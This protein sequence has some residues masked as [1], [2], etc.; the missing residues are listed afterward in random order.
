MRFHPLRRWLTVLVLLLVAIP[1]ARSVFAQSTPSI[2]EIFQARLAAVATALGDNPRYKK[3][4]PQYRERLTE[5]VAGNMLFVLVHELAHAAVSEL[6]LPVLGKEEDA[7][8]AF[9]ATRLIG[10]GSM[11]SSS[12]RHGRGG[13]LVHGRSPRP[14]GRRHG[15]LLR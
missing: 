13:R 7:A 15:P 6:G 12:R 4:S 2:S 9:A 10:I 3:L 5:F 1:A 14:G 11:V 8:D